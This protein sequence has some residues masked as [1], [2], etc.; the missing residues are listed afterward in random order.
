[1][2]KSKGRRPAENAFRAAVA[3]RPEV[4]AC[5]QTGLKALGSHSQKII[6]ADRSKCEGSLD[7]DACTLALYPDQSRWDYALAYDSSGSWVATPPMNLLI[8][9]QAK[10]I[11]KPT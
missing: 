5:Y 7:L 2:P 9:A 11:F 3:A 1:M 8:L 4:A 6:P 10:C